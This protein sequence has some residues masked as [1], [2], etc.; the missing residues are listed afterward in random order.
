MIIIKSLLPTDHPGTMKPY[1]SIRALIS[2]KAASTPYGYTDD[3]VKKVFGEMDKMAEDGSDKEWLADLEIWNTL[4]PKEPVPQSLKEYLL[5]QTGD[6]TLFLLVVKNRSRNAPDP[7]SR[8]ASPPQ[9]DIEMVI[10]AGSEMEVELTPGGTNENLQQKRS[11][12]IQQEAREKGRTEME[13]EPTLGS[14]ENLQRK[15]SMPIQQ[16]T[17]KKARTAKYM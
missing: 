6:C 12:P 15:R 4:F 17:C 13:V 16:E 1:E 5:E 10:A 2:A 9:R 7:A 8:S 3:E 14:N 11:M